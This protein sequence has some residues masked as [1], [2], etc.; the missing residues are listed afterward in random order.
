MQRCLSTI[1]PCG[2]NRIHSS[3]CRTVNPSSRFN[4]QLTTMLALLSASIFCQTRSQCAGEQKMM[5]FFLTITLWFADM[6]QLKPR[7]FFI[8]C[9]IDTII[10]IL[11]LICPMQ[12]RFNWGISCLALLVHCHLYFSFLRP[13]VC[14][15][16]PTSS[17]IKVQ[18]TSASYWTGAESDH[19][20]ISSAMIMAII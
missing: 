3:C 18:C 15:I 16:E 14:L 11:S 13:S 9:H 1:E 5:R 19:E 8:R 20:L 2:T 7:Y 17:S 6:S 12:V 4:T 10:T